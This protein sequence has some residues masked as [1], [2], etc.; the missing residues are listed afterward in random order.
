MFAQNG[1]KFLEIVVGTLLLP[2]GAVGAHD[3]PAV[4]AAHFQP[5]EGRRGRRLGA[6]HRQKA[7]AAHRQQTRFVQARGKEKLLSDAE[8]FAVVFFLRLLLRP[9]GNDDAGIF[10]Q[11]VVR[12]DSPAR[13]RV[14]CGDVDIG[15]A[16]AED[17]I[18]ALVGK[19]APLVTQQKVRLAAQ[20]RAVQ[21]LVRA[22]EYADDNL[23]IGCR[24]RH[25]GAL[26]FRPVVAGKIADIQVQLAVRA[27]AHRLLAHLVHVREDGAA[28]AGKVLARGGEAEF[29]AFPLDKFYAQLR[30]ERG[31]LLGNRRLGDK[32]PFRR[33]G[34]A[35]AVGNGNKIFHLPKQHRLAPPLFY[36]FPFLRPESILWIKSYFLLILFHQR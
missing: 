24:K 35:A 17:K 7:A 3:A 11:L 5:H 6:R 14:S 13:E 12:N 27:D 21:L 26:Q 28:A 1:S 36:F 15:G 4:C 10:F 34:E 16:L 9:V 20:N 19:D 18:F 25:D 8:I 22:L 30:F 23:G 33:L 32:A 31:N 2:K 29:S